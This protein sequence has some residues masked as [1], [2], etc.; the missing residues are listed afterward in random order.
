[1]ILRAPLTTI[2]GYF[3]AGD[4]CQRWSAYWIGTTLAL[5]GLILYRLDLLREWKGNSLDAVTM[6]S[7]CATVLSSIDATVRK[8]YRNTFH[9]DPANAVRSTFTAAV[10]FS[11]CWVLIDISMHRVSPWLT[12]REW[13]A[14]IYLGIVPTAIAN[15]LFNKAEDSL[16]IPITQ[17]I[18][19][20][21]PFFTLGIGM[22][23]LS[24][25]TMSHQHLVSRH[26]IGLVLTVVGAIIVTLFAGVKRR[27]PTPP[28]L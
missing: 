28:L 14:V 1:M 17:S 3:I 2:V 22:I 6:F 19:C 15:I 18:N 13:I 7:L 4:S 12:T 21:G 24:F 20:L 16:S 26:Y 23:P 8:R 9:V 5:F 25:F 10:I 11:L 27:L